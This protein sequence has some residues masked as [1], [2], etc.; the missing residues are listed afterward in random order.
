MQNGVQNQPWEGPGAT[1]GVTWG[2]LGSQVAPGFDFWVILE[3]KWLPKGALGGSQN[4]KKDV[5]NMVFFSCFFDLVFKAFWNAQGLLF[6]SFFWVFW[7]V[8]RDMAKIEKIAS[9]VR[10][11][12][13]TEG[14]G[15]SK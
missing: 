7:S 2:G 3:P 9:R 15:R 8:F 10:E 6:G 5:K 12:A 14:R 4:G 1:W 13:K 11:S